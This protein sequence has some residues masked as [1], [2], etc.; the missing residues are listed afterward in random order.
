MNSEHH[1]SYGKQGN[2]KISRRNQAGPLGIFGMLLSALGILICLAIFG[3]SVY[4]DFEAT[5]FDNPPNAKE[6][7]RPFTCPIVIDI[8]EIGVV[9]ATVKNVSPAIVRQTVIGYFGQ[10]TSETMREETFKSYFDP[11][12]A[13]EVEWEIAADDAVGDHLILVKVH[14][15]GRLVTPA[16]ESVCGVLVFDLPGNFTGTQVLIFLIVAGLALMVGGGRVWW[17][18][19]VPRVPFNPAEKWAV[20]SLIVIIVVGLFS[21]YFG[22]FVL[23]VALFYIATLITGVMLPHFFLSHRK[24]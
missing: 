15:K 20:I 21:S 4:A 19:S 12:E 24:P 5:M 6:T 17:A 22:I 11:Y 10:L 14:L 13:K 7:I 1:S 23:A 9:R 8:D 16:R 2:Q 3:A 18:F